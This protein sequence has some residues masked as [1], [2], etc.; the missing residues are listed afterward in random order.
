M[1]T[2]SCIHGYTTGP[3][4]YKSFSNR[5]IWPIDETQT[6]TITLAA[7]GPGSNDNKIIFFAKI[8]DTKLY[9]YHN[10]EYS[11]YWSHLYCL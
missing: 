8:S 11:D 3:I 2:Y 10:L 6:Y 9:D 7:S 1:Y 4:K 5:S